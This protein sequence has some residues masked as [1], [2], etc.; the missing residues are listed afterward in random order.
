MAYY[1]NVLTLL[2]TIRTDETNEARFTCTDDQGREFSYEGNLIRVDDIRKMI[3]D[4]CER[5]AHL[6]RSVCF[7]GESRPASLTLDINI[8]KLVDNLQNTQ[9]GYCFVDDPRN[10]FVSH[11]SSYGEWLLCDTK[12]ASDFVYVYQDKVIWKPKPCME[13]LQKL[14]ELRQLLLLLCIFSAG[15][16]SRASEV[17]RQLLRNVPGSYRNLLILFHVVC[18]VDIQDKT[19][20]KHLRDKYIPHCPTREVATL[21]VYNLAIF[22]PFEEHLALVILGEEHSLRYHQQ[23]WPD[24]RDT[25]SD[26]RISDAIGRECTHYLASK[27]CIT[28]VTYKILFWRNLVTAILKRQTDVTISAAHQQYYVDTAMMH[29][30]G[31]A[32]ARYGGDSSN[33]PMSDP[34]QVVECIKVGLA[35]HKLIN[36]GQRRP[37]SV[38]IDRQLEVLENDNQR[39]FLLL[40]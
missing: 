4:I 20:H 31:M 39:M 22:R 18:L 8:D 9:P 10:P 29:S 13:L 33:L 27:A 14:Q 5:Y 34:R 19:S 3:M 25:I 6:E 28:R 26:T 36:V 30:S 16:S 35:W 2:A 15:P 38:D 12:R 40:S 1:Y 32:V 17:A 11:R 24:L 37:L 23:L 21:L 7:F